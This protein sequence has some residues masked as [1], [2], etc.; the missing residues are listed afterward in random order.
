VLSEALKAA[1]QNSQQ[2]VAEFLVERNADP[3]PALLQAS[4]HGDAQFV[5][6][7][8]AAGADANWSDEEGRTALM[9]A[10]AY[11][12]G[13]VT[14]GDRRADFKGVRRLLLAA[15]AKTDSQ[16]ERGMTVLHYAVRGRAKETV[17][18]LL[19]E[20]VV[21]VS[22]VHATA[23]HLAVRNSSVEITE[24]LINA[25]WNPNELD[26]SR[27]APLHYAAGKKLRPILNQ[28]S[29][30]SADALTIG[31]EESELRMD[32][33]IEEETMRLRRIIPLLVK[34]GADPNL[35][36]G[37]GKTA[38]QIAE[39]EGFTLLAEEIQKHLSKP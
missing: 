34:A 14:F 8:L 19:D 15:G 35:T 27:C 18:S 13:T 25:G 22:K 16:D 29:R 3:N 23:L 11:D 36:D 38:L 33:A 2:S 7:M 10:C 6:R 17:R 28:M 20:K 32:R 31:E 9:A 37:E 5:E 1:A 26:L 12:D 4:S 39:E 24:I 30:L 21:V